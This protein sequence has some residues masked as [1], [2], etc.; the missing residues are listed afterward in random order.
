MRTYTLP[1]F[2]LLIYTFLLLPQL[3]YASPPPPT[4]GDEQEEKILEQRILEAVHR[5]REYVLGFLVYDVRVVDLQISQD[6]KWAI[7]FLEM[8]DPVSG[9]TIPGE[10]G[11]A[12]AQ[13]LGNEWIITLPAD[14]GWA[15]LV[16]QIPN[17]LL[18]EA[19]KNVYLA[20]NEAALQET[21]TVYTGY[22]LPWEAGKTVYLSQSVGHDRYIP[23]GSAHYAFDFYISKTMFRLYASKAGT[24]W[25]ARWDVPDGDDSDMGNYLV[26][27]DTTTNP[28][29]YQLYLH[30]AQD[31][32]PPA[33]RTPGAY[34]AQGQFIG[35]ADDTGQSTGH[36]LHFQ[37]H[38]NPDSYWGTALDITFDDVDIN[39]GRPRVSSDAPYC[40]PT[41][42]CEDFRSAYISGN[43]IRGD[44]TPPL[45]GITKPV[46]GITI[47]TD[48]VQIEGWAS[49]IGS[50]VDKAQIMANY[51]GVWHTVGEFDSPSTFTLDWDM[52]SDQVPDGPVS[53]SVR[54]WDNEGN[55]S[56]GY[57]GLTHIIKDYECKP[58][59]PA[60][61][62]AQFQVALFTETDFR[63][64]CVLLGEGNYG[65]LSGLYPAFEDAVQSILVG[66]Q[67]LA[68]LF[69]EA[70]FTGRSSTHQSSDANLSDNPSGN[71]SLSSLKIR[72]KTISASTPKELIY[73]LEGSTLPGGGSA[74]L[75]WR[76]SGGG[77]EFQVKVTTPTGIVRSPWV[78]KP[79]WHLDQ[80]PLIPGNY[81]WQVR[82]R[83]CVETSCWS[84]WSKPGTFSVSAPPADLPTITAPI[85]DDLEA[86]SSNWLSSGF[87]NRLSD[88]QRAHSGTYA[89]YYGNPE[90]RHYADGKA[91]AGDLTF[92][93]VYIPSTGYTLRFWYRYE[94]ESDGS[95]WDQRWVQISENGGPF[96]NVRQLFDEVQN[97][98]LQATIDLSKF[99]GK[100][101][102]IR[103]HFATLDQVANADF[104][105]W[106]IDDLEVIPMSLPECADN[107]N[108]PS[109]ARVLTF[110]QTL[111]GEMCP[112][113]DVD[114]YKFEGTAGDHIVVD[115][116]TP[117]DSNN[118]DLDL[119]LYLLDGDGESVLSIHDDEIYAEKLDPHLGYKLTRSGTYF[120]KA[121]LWAFPTT[122]GE[123]FTYQITLTKDNQKP[124]AKFV[125]PTSN[126]FL[127]DTPIIEL[128]LDAS[129]SLSGISQAEFL[130]HSGDWASSTWKSLGVD[131]NGEDGWSFEFD[132]S[133]LPE[134]KDLAFFANVFDWAGNWKGAG[135]FDLGIDRT[136]PTT[137]M[138]PL[139]SS[140]TSTAI[141]LEWNGSDNL[142]GIDHFELQVQTGNGSWSNYSPDPE[143][144]RT[145]L[146][147]I[148]NA[149][150]DYG[151]RI[152]G[153]DHAAN[154]EAYPSSAETRTTIPSASV[155]CSAPDEWDSNKNDNSPLNAVR[156]TAGD[157]SRVHNFCNPLRS[158]R[159]NDEDW[160]RFSVES[161][162]TYIIQ[163]IPM[164]PMSATIL[165]LYDSDGTTLL[166][167]ARS[168]DLGESAQIIWKSDEARDIY[169]RVRHLN[170]GI[171][172]NPVAYRLSVGKLI[173]M[174]LPIIGH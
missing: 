107:D 164:S 102:E 37:V 74:S 142:S 30:L 56:T 128:K 19:Q 28:T 46:T 22:L 156:I 89:W 34:V 64:D 8:S 80:E 39:G 85:T 41:D 63:G 69:S 62:P 127:T 13:R 36:H 159:L 153:V 78:K 6:G 32:I 121:R 137:F 81:S 157:P 61:I 166:L 119:V 141:L 124:A 18:T 16:E 132:L 82:A 158:D 125:N 113:G 7:A 83:S 165:E 154:A 76:D 161:A 173:Q 96:R 135:V 12:I 147:F 10:P 35:I 139:S 43:V 131:Q 101:I 72:K 95:I 114:Y 23:S 150:N 118:P 99:A 54:V 144:S 45:G 151:F 58:K 168:K 126:T 122:G 90:A 111:T 91:N 59:P 24:V 117:S 87:W 60:C 116:N 26:L 2:I 65:D 5:Q 49:D 29:T 105:G 1:V 94:T 100:T 47:K 57:P 155:L 21:T 163:A 40:R 145:K 51:D 120:A 108:S 73:P 27:Q 130:W 9:E 123:D 115:I 68:T 97:Q 109:K 75:H 50:G 42:V 55:P 20:L 169:L 112:T 162:K 38:S 152:R 70:D 48:V 15:N 71:N 98:W 93:P 129:D 110:G 52:C 171:I 53:L 88:D 31:S 84:A 146:W 77:L 25:R 170:G 11:L 174:F 33:L 3:S 160:I 134:Q 143:G 92:R 79:F 133:R 140:Q 14:V 104:E 67:V 167:E 44:L 66:D 136:P 17:E 106:Y 103:F 172:G 138:K 149:S 4:P 148:G 86:G